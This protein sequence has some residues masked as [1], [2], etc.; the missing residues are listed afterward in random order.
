MKIIDLTLPY[1]PAMPGVEIEQAKT[2]A[3]DGWN[4]QTL[5]LYSHAGTHMDAPWH[6][7]VSNQTID[8]LSLDQCIGLCRIADLGAVT[9]KHLITVEDLGPVADKTGEGDSLIIKTGWSQFSGTDKYRHEL[10]RI[11][12]GLAQWCVEKKIKMLGVE[13]PSV[14]DVNNLEEVT[15]IHKILLSGNVTIVEGL[16]N[17]SAIEKETFTLIVLPL[18]IEGGDGAPARAIALEDQIENG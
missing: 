7:G 18:K 4:A 14:A 9:P 10:P 3:A 16:T 12:E 6:F 8:Q 2:L 17:L 15:H 1:N 5:H 11:S 13:P